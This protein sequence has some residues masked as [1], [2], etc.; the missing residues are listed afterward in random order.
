MAATYSFDV[1]SDFDQQEL[2]N[3][4]DQTTREVGTRYD[5]KDTKTQLE[6]EPTQLVINSADEF[7]LRSVQDILESRVVRRGLS[8]KILDYQKAE[9]ASGGRVRQV[10][11]LKKGI[12][13]DLAKQLVREIRAD[14]KKV[15]PQIQGDA[16]RISG[17]NKDD[18]QEVIQHLRGQDFPVALQFVNYR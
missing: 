5:L 11:K 1:V 10:V 14:Y 2:K 7:T 15:T 12:P 13:E 9:D 18:L 8:L 4:V 3:A 16:I 17:K 6:L